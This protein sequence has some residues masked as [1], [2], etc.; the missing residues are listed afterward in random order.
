MELPAS[1]P[2]GQA[3][4]AAFA[5]ALRGRST[6]L[7]ATVFQEEVNVKKPGSCWDKFATA[8]TLESVY[9]LMS[10]HMQAAINFA[11][12]SAGGTGVSLCLFTDT[13]LQNGKVTYE[14]DL[15]NIY[16]KTGD[17]WHIALPQLDNSLMYGTYL[18]FYMHTGVHQIERCR[19]CL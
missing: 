15:H 1:Q 13:D 10:E 16:N 14:V 8:C 19:F 7:G 9:T 5:D 12:Y 3:A 4:S 6:P 18:L 11:L 17:V 2:S